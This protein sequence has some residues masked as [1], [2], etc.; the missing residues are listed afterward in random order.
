MRRFGLI[1]K[2]GMQ[3]CRLPRVLAW[4][5]AGLCACADSFYVAPEGKGTGSG[6]DDAARF[7]VSVLNREW[8]QNSNRAD[9]TIFFLP[10]TY[11]VK[12]TNRPTDYN[13]RLVIANATHRT[14]RLK[15]I[16]D[17]KGELPVLVLAPLDRASPPLLEWCPTW[18]PRSGPFCDWL[19]RTYSLETPDPR[20]REYLNRIEI[21]NLAF[22]G[23]F[24]G[25]G[26]PTSASN[27]AGYKSF[28]IDVWAKTGRIRNVVARNFG[29]VGVVP[30]SLADASQSGVESFPITFGSFWQGQPPMD[31]DDYPWVIE[32]S[33]VSSFHS[34]H[35]GYGTM[36]SG[37]VLSTN[38]WTADLPPVAVVRRCRVLTPGNFIAF[39]T[40]GSP[41]FGTGRIRIQDCV[42]LNVS[43][44]FNTDT[45]RISNWT[46]THCFFLDTKR[47]GQLGLPDSGP[48]HINFTVADNFIRIRGRD[49][50]PLYS[51]FFV[52]NRMIWGSNPNLPLGRQ[53]PEMAT[54]LIFQGCASN[55]VFSNNWFTTWPRTNFF[56]PDAA[57]TNFASFCPVWSVPSQAYVNDQ[58]YARF[59]SNALNVTMSHG[60]LSATAFEFTGTNDW[61]NYVQL[62][63][64]S[65]G[66]AKPY[67]TFVPA[68][69]ASP[70]SFSP[71]GRVERIEMVTQGPSVS[72]QLL[73]V[74]EI[75]FGLCD[76]SASNPVVRV[77][78]VQHNS[79][80]SA[81]G[82]TIPLVGNSVWLTG[83]VDIPGG[84]V[85]SL[86]TNSAVTS[87][88][89]LAVFPANWGISNGYFR[90]RA[91]LSPA[92][93]TNSVAWAS[94][95]LS[96]GAVIRLFASP[97]VA[98]DKNPNPGKR[99]RLHFVRAGSL[100]NSLK[101][102][103]SIPATGI[104]SPVDQ[105]NLMADYGDQSGQDYTLQPLE[106]AILVPTIPGSQFQLTFPT[107][108]AE[109]VL[110]MVPI[111]D[112][113]TEANVARFILNP[114]PSY[115]VGDP[116]Q[117][118]VLI[119]DGP[120]WN[121]VAMSSTH[122]GTFA[123]PVPT[124]GVAVNNSSNHV[125]VGY[126]GAAEAPSGH[127]WQGAIWE[128]P[129][130][131]NPNGLLPSSSS[132]SYF[133]TAVSDGGWTV[134]VRSEDKHPF[135]AWR[136]IGSA[137]PI[138]L[139]PLRSNL[140]FSS[141]AL[142]IS[143]SGASVV[144][145]SDSPSNA[146]HPVIWTNG[147]SPADLFPNGAAGNGFA[148]GVNDQGIVV[149]E[150][151]I[152]RSGTVRQRGF[153]TKPFMAIKEPADD[154]LPPNNAAPANAA[155]TA[156]AVNAAGASVGSFVQGLARRNG[157]YWPPRG[158]VGTNPPA[159]WVAP[160][161]PPTAPGQSDL[162]CE[163][164]ALND[165]GW[166][167]GWSRSSDGQERAVLARGPFSPL[168][169][170]ND[171][172]FV[173]GIDGW[174]LTELRSI[175]NQNWLIG[176]ANH[177]GVNQAVMLVPRIPGK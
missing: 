14:I 165:Y 81:I 99:A 159:Q 110:E 71:Q 147:L 58:W 56:L 16:L 88:Q 130:W 107:N 120:L 91:W 72:N 136:K 146:I 10:G 74:R 156:Y 97:D 104:S 153:R 101:I 69:D 5:I 158:K 142:A 138:R 49:N 164:L 38:R 117:T 106:N 163:L 7:D 57:S 35:N 175:N 41:T 152:N 170:L 89:G 22:D 6:T 2:D 29:A 162:D 31:G 45:F 134:G 11:L 169:D 157:A 20:Q 53:I 36:I 83:E 124:F 139:P 78:A 48:G 141:G 143:P 59:R 90:L 95:N 155:T 145:F 50:L 150:L 125:M 86:P 137:Q 174:Y 131:T 133:P 43:V 47:L 28:G 82:G 116:H 66:A 39:G 64:L 96:R 1:E 25:Q 32:D 62:P 92:F 84:G 15:G 23:D 68:I 111:I 98:D 4:L 73:A 54:G 176:N 126:V 3:F 33:E 166:L 121:L 129:A 161:I 77:R 21:E 80:R 103:F 132:I 168:I 40:G 154:L 112:N 160:W 119:Y 148:R 9:I 42:S 24:D 135:Q 65:P 114:G 26:A 149:G 128:A 67:T 19:L 109:A 30:I 61:G 12:G 18:P 171:S 44:G 8:L 85:L 127:E 60:R 76:L 105:R 177:G 172:H 167:V 123:S 55:V 63:V 108:Q 75:A 118:D 34:V 37:Q 113:L 94:L 115:V 51:D 144:G 100:T 79:F 93:D 173:S 17:A 46:V 87:S 52:T 70:V 102:S 140:A 122:S 13:Q 151:E 27:D